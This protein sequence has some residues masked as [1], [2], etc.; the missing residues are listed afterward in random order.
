MGFSFVAP[1]KCCEGV[2]ACPRFHKTQAEH[3]LDSK[4]HS[5]NWDYA[6]TASWFVIMGC[7]LIGRDLAGGMFL[8]AAFVTGPSCVHVPEFLRGAFLQLPRARGTLF[9]VLFR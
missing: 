9:H 6:G 7:I 3:D 5:A 4:D 2:R 1:G 8:L